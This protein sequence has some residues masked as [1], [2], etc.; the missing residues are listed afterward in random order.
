M[1]G[2]LGVP[3]RVRDEVFGNLYLTEPANGEFTADDEEIVLA[4]AATAGVA[5]DNARLFAEGE[6]RQRALE[7]STFITRQL[8]SI[9]GEEPL[10]VIARQLRELA[11]ADVVSVVLPMPDG[12]NLLVEVASGLRED[13]LLGLTYPAEGSLAGE[14]IATGRPINIPDAAESLDNPVHLSSFLPI[15][16]TMVLPL[17]TP[18]YARGALVVGRLTGRP[19]FADSDV[20]MA[21]TFA[22]HATVALELADARSDQERMALL[23]D[24]DRIA[25]DLHDHVIQRLFA[26]GLTI[27]GIGARLG[28]P[29]GQRLNDIVTELDTTIAQIRT[30]IFELRGP[31]GPQTGTLRSRLVA[32]LNELEDVLDFEP[33]M[34]MSGPLD[35]VVPDDATDDVLAVIREALTNIAKHARAT[36]VDVS[37]AARDG[38]LVLDVVDDGVGLCE[39]IRRSGL[40]NLAHRAEAHGGTFTVEPADAGSNERKGTHLQWLI[41]LP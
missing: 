30:S 2:F 22:N 39:T 35:S 36:R 13:D 29:Q 8:L 14:A 4:L 7:A 17:G 26:A 9:E 15:G 25:R 23:E 12:R 37:V 1:S 3:I 20:D 5:I 19:H 38:V 6:H 31:L 10:A 28:G 21:T 40:E 24:R 27:Q 32:L 41:P 18:D 33:Q 11:D 16:P 34:R